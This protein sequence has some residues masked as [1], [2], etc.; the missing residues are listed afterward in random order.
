MNQDLQQFRKPLKVSDDKPV[1]CPYI[2]ADNIFKNISGVP[3][4]RQISGAPVEKI[5]LPNL[6]SRNP[7]DGFGKNLCKN[8]SPYH[9]SFFG[10]S[11]ECYSDTRCTNKLNTCLDPKE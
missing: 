6:S 2:K 4:P 10:D 11:N 1:Y 5:C 8:N 3:T 9:I 7:P